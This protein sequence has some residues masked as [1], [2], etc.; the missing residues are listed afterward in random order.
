MERSLFNKDIIDYEIRRDL[1]YFNDINNI[2]DHYL[3]QLIIINNDKI[4]N[5]DKIKL[6]NYNEIH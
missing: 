4:N 2:N 3:N 6:P 1:I 5:N